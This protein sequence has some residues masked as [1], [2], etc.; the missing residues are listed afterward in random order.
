MFPHAEARAGRIDD[1]IRVA[2]ADGVEQ[3]RGIATER[4]GRDTTDRAREHD[5]DLADLGRCH[6]ARLGEKV[7]LKSDLIRE[8]VGLRVRSKLETFLLWSHFV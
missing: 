3:L 7:H 6:L 4:R 8:T 1:V 2:D 5:I